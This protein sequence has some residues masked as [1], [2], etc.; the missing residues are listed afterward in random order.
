MLPGEIG[1]GA[2]WPAGA[3][4]P[5]F[6][7][8]ECGARLQLERMDIRS[9]VAKN[10]APRI[11]VARDSAFAWPRPVMKLPVPP[12]APSAPPSERCKRT[13]AINAT[14]IRM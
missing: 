11:A 3:G 8:I 2:V 13:T 1:V 4:A 9:A 6:S 12:P 10:I 14:T 7:R 5:P